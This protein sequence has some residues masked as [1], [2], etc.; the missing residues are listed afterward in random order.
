VAAKVRLEEVFKLSGVP[1]Y[2]FVEPVEYGRLL[3]ALRTPGR[4][5]VIEGPSGIGKTTAVTRALA[6]VPGGNGALR[7]TA[8]RRADREIIEALPEMSAAGIVVIDDFHR[9]GD[10]TRSAIADYLKLLADEE[11]TTT[12]IVIL[13]INRAGESLVSFARDLSGRLDVIRFESNPAE[14]VQRLVR[15]G[16]SVLNINLPEKE[17]A[18]AALGS[19][20]IAQLL[21]HEACVASNFYEEQVLTQHLTVPLNVVLERV[22]DDLSM[23][24]MEIAMKF[25]TGPRFSKEGRAPYL[26]ILRW[27]S[28]GPEWTINLEREVRRHPEL[29][30]SVSQVIDRHLGEF[31]GRNNDLGDL[32]HFDERTNVLAVEDPKFFF[33]IKHLS[34]A[35]F[36]ERVGYLNIGYST[37]YDFALSFAGADRAIAKG[38]ASALIERE[39]AVFYDAN[40]QARILA[41]NLEEYLAPIY[42]SEASF[43]VCLLSDAYPERV[44]TRFESKQFKSRFGAES[45][46]P[47]WFTSSPPGVMDA[48]AAVGSYH[49]RL[50]EPVDPQI[51]LL[52]DLLKDK[53]A[54]FRLLPKLDPGNFRCRQCHLVQSTNLLAEGRVSLCLD[55][56]EKFKIS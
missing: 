41:T 37:K 15:E 24:F 38:I 31:L 14:R 12:K 42:Q 9:L 29:R 51:D 48:A 3:V 16:A 1:S 8:R 4:G 19:F 33:F 26:H 35:K 17:I 13:G 7:L 39:F 22:V 18:A 45:V 27:L 11:D 23:N 5:V 25:A 47:V 53:L 10:A 44:W 46:I 40:E 2:T 21:C 56:A 30:S 52:A 54:D 6:E 36:A 28:E 32:L 43:V 49:L 50:E 34:W 55:C 20:H